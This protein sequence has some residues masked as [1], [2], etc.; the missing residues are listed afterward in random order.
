MDINNN[1]L[2]EKLKEL[3]QKPGVYQMI[4]PLGNIIYVGKAKNLKNRVSQ[5]FNEQK[6]RIPKV[7]EMIQNI[8]TFNYLVTDTELDA[9]IDECQL[10]KDIQPRYNHLMKNYRKYIFIKIPS[11]HFPKLLLVNEKIDDDGIYFGPFT[12][13]H[14]VKVAL[15]FMKEFYPIRKCPSPGIVKRTNG[16]LYRQMG[17]CLGICTGEVSTDEYW[18][19]PEKIRELL[20][21]NDQSPVQELYQSMDT[22]SKNLQFEKAAQY[23]EYYLALKHVIRKQQLILSSNKNRMILAVEFIDPVLLK[24]FLIKGN[25]LLG[26]RLLNIETTIDQTDLTRE[27]KQFLTENLETKKSNSNKLTQYDIDEAHARTSQGTVL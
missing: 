18:M 22:A 19:H 1:D 24:L 26:R 17:T 25:K 13:P 14:R 10:L 7:A 9:L 3:P 21:G 11:G 23:H 12:S 27:L 5:Y 8:Q 4:D 2:S 6:N 16:C 20:N 15:Q